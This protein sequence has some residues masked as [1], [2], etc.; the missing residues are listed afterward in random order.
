M[1]FRGLMPWVSATAIGL[2]ALSSAAFA[3]PVETNVAIERAFVDGP[4]GQVHVRIA[5]PGVESDKAPLVLFH[6]SPYSSDYFVP[7]M[8]RL[9]KDRMVIAIDTPGYGDSDRPPA[10]ATIAEYAASAREALEGLGF[11]SSGDK[12][13]DVL[14]YHTG[15]LIATELA[16][17]EPALVR[18]LVLPG[19][20]FFVGEERRKTYEENVKPETLHEDGEHLAAKWEFA[21]GALGVGLELSRAQEHFNDMM[22]CQP[23]CWWSYHGVFSYESDVQFPKIKQPVLLISYDGSLEE[24][25]KAARAFIETAEHVHIDGVTKGAFDVAVDKLA[26]QTKKFLDKK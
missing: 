21:S 4:Y 9:A 14:G 20:P 10:P 15:G 17:M 2:A 13:I 26:K 6:P 12:Q 16:I 25:T 24:E 23:Y 11:S 7:F 19:L 3:A 1:R 8:H 18:R 22:Q 5:Q